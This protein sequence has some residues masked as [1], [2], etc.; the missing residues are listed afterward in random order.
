M[1]RRYCDC[2]GKRC[3]G[4]Q[5]E[6]GRVG[7]RPL[8]AQNIRNQTAYASVAVFMN[9]MLRGYNGETS[10]QTPDLCHTCLVGILR[11]LAEDRK[12]VV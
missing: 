8:K 5:P 6:K 4:G 10:M 9:G 11:E 12:S 7:L 1:E 2:C 3:P